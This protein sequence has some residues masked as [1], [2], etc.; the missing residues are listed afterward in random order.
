MGEE[1]WVKVSWVSDNSFYITLPRSFAEQLE[2]E[3]R[4]SICSSCPCYPYHFSKK[5]D[6]IDLVRTMPG[7]T[8]SSAVDTY[9][10]LSQKT[11]K[12][13]IPMAEAENYITM[14]RS[15]EEDK[16]TFLLAYLDECKQHIWNKCADLGSF[17]TTGLSLWQLIDKLIY[18]NAVLKEKKTAVKKKKISAIEEEEVLPDLT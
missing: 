14:W 17:E 4:L 9:M 16:H 5:S 13:Q 8:T 10:N 7:I 6:V 11:T 3:G 1:L 12:Q 18:E 15:P 2:E